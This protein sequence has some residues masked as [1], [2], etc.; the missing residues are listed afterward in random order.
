MPPPDKSSSKA[1]PRECAGSVLTTSV[2]CPCSASLTPIALAVVVLPTPPLPPQKM[3]LLLPALLLPLSS[4]KSSLRP[5]ASDDTLLI[6]SLLCLLAR[7]EM[8]REG[9]D[10]VLP[11][12]ADPKHDWGKA[13]ARM[14]LLLI[15]RLWVLMAE[16]AIVT[17]GRKGVLAGVMCV[18]LRPNGV[19]SEDRGER[20]ST[21]GITPPIESEKTMPFR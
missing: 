3:Y 4:T 5:C 20:S 14:G 6:A 18:V 12:T 21:I 11:T 17:V 15:R 10:D 2:V 19:Q 13:A 16:L 7:S 1:S 8:L 9:D